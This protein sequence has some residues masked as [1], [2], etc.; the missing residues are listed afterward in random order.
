M[1]PSYQRLFAKRLS[2]GAL[3]LCACASAPE[4]TPRQ[5]SASASKPGAFGIDCGEPNAP[6]LAEGSLRLPA[7]WV[8]ERGDLD[9][10]VQAS[11]PFAVNEVW[12]AEAKGCEHQYR[13][14]LP[15]G[16]IRS[17]LEQLANTLEVTPRIDA[18]G[19]RLEA[20]ASREGMA[21]VL[22]LAPVLDDIANVDIGIVHRGVDG[23]ACLRTAVS[24][25]PPSLRTTSALDATGATA[26]FASI[27]REEGERPWCEVR[28]GWSHDR[29]KILGKVRS[30]IVQRGHSIDQ[31]SRFEWDDGGH[32]S[33]A[34]DGAIF[35]T[36]PPR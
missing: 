22:V 31:D 25:L 10:F 5:P 1:T 34:W 8:V 35:D 23:A 3:V 12:R 17:R 30:W 33:V 6:V 18:T 11:A 32:G 24:T 16:E 2:L 7:R 9:A 29:E 19:F 20:D 26:S 13:M 21:F 27:R 14:R 28:Y 15:R 36:R 4:R